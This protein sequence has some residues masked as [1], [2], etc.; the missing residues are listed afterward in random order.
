MMSAVTADANVNLT[1]QELTVHL[2]NTPDV[3]ADANVNM[4]LVNCYLLI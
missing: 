2:E 4:H 3:T 1:G